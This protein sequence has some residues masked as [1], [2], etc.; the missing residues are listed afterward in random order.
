MTQA[1]ITSHQA[2][3]YN[4]IESGR[5]VK[6]HRMRWDPFERSDQTVTGQDTTPPD[7]AAGRDLTL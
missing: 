4:L 6:R 3:M 5:A 7:V 1:V 2:V